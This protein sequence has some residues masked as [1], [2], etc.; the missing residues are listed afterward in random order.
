MIR[1]PEKLTEGAETD[2]AKFERI[3]MGAGALRSY[4]VPELKNYMDLF[5]P[6]SRPDFEALAEQWVKSQTYKHSMFKQSGNNY[7][8]YNQAS[9]AS[10]GTYNNG[11]A[12][13]GGYRK[14]MSCFNCGK[15]G[16]MARDCRSGSVE[17]TKQS[18]TPAMTGEGKLIVCFLCKEVGHRSPQY[19]KKEDKI[20]R[21]MIKGM[22]SWQW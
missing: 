3:T 10:R 11:S 18:S 2:R 22:M 20:K 16:H 7:K 21:V 19:P 12:Q 1:W 8:Q 6:A 13:W 15:V 9:E 5:K 17:T 14:P 4:M